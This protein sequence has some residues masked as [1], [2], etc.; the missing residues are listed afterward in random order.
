MITIDNLE[1]TYANQ[2]QPALAIESLKIQAGS[3][4]VLTGMSGSGKSTLLRVLNGLIPEYF[5]G[6]LQGKVKING[7]I[8]KGQSIEEIAAS[9]GS[10]FQNPKRQFFFS[11]VSDELAF[12]AE[13]QGQ[14]PAD[15]RARI[16]KA[17]QEFGL[18]GLLAAKIPTLSGGQKQ[19]IALVAAQMQAPKVLVLDEPTANLDQVGIELL[20]QNLFKLKQAGL[21]IVIA[22]HRLDYLQELADEYHYFTRGKLVTSWTKDDWLKLTD[23]M[24]LAYGLRPLMPKKTEQVTA[25]EA[26]SGKIMLKLDNYQLGWHQKKLGLVRNFELESGR[27][28]ALTGVNGLGKTSLA[29]VLVG[30]KNNHQKL[31]WNGQK[32]KP[33]QL[34]AKSSYLMQDV[35]SQL[36]LPTVEA[37]LSSSGADKTAVIKTATQLNLGNLLQRHPF[38]LSGGQQQRVALGRVLLAKKELFILDEPTSGLDEKNMQQVAKLICSLKS[39]MRIILVI[40]HDYELINLACDQVL[41]LSDFL[42]KK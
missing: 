10:V 27:I 41:N 31:T 34:L 14:A 9:V 32:L 25:N 39:P 26:T 15:I 37:E 6:N 11:K 40:S 38:S 12:P 29:K 35:G 33:T 17:E 1:F 16:K 4:V 5:P 20:K 23:E 19:R 13:N 21:T 8:L 42:V 3:C 28:Y 24:R 36:F 30:L 7:H 18:T 22:E 2:K